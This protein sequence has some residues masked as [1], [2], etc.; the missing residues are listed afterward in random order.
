[1]NR[2]SFIGSSALGA[3]GLMLSPALVAEA[4]AQTVPGGTTFVERKANF[5][6]A[7]FAR[8]VG[9]PAEYRFL[10]EAA[11]YIPSFLNNVKNGING[12]Q[13]G[14]GA[15]PSQI[16]SVVGG[17]GPS[18]SYTYTDYVW[19]K[20]RIGEFFSI[21][22]AVT[23]DPFTKNTFFAKRATST[24]ADPDD[25]HG[26]Y[27]DASVEA[28]QARGVTFM[29]CHTAVE[30]Q[31]RALV[32]RGFAPAGMTQPDVA[33]D[34]LTHLIPGAL[35]VPSMVATIAIIQLRYRYAYLNVG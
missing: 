24:S 14:F 30:E 3:S 32:K 22:D 18:S 28:L 15:D 13:F 11:A 17:H 23:G 1:M 26:P 27:Q 21:K 7:S 10:W 4:D 34:I 19:Q 12:A 33:N 16:N 29:T 35:V 9:R 31:A 8:I 20:Y 25:E 5:D 2:S 6:E